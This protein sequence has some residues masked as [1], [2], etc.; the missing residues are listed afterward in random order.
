MCR[1]AIRLLSPHQV[2]GRLPFVGELPTDGK[3][4]SSFYLTES[5]VPALYETSLLDIDG[6]LYQQGKAFD[7]HGTE[8]FMLWAPVD[9]PETD[10]DADVGEFVN[11]CPIGMRRRG[12]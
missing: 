4:G 11:Q 2:L 9:R 6:H 8:M 5:G 3:Y 12:R 1:A 10:S 7:A